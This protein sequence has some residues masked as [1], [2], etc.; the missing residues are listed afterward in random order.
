MDEDPA[1]PPD[2]EDPEVALRR[3]REQ[4][5]SS[6]DDI[7]EGVQRAIVEGPQALAACRDSV[8]RLAGVA[9]MVGLPQVS[10]R[11]LDLEAVLTGHAPGTGTV[12]SAVDQLRR[13]FSDDLAGPPPPWL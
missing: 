3:A 6:F 9:G 12:Y 10:E 5:I 7:C 1:P 8:H 2:P 4:L 13:A 11:A